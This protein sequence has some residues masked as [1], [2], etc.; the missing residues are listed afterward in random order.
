MIFGCSSNNKHEDKKVHI[1]SSDGVKNAFDVA[2]NTITTQSDYTKK[3]KLN[4]S[5]SIMFFSNG[6]D[7]LNILQMMTIDSDSNR[8]FGFMRSEKL[9][10]C[11]NSTNLY[12]S[13]FPTYSVLKKDGQ[14]PNDV[15][16]PIDMVY[17]RIRNRIY[18]ADLVAYAIYIYDTKFNEI[19][20]IKLQ[21]KPYRLSLGNDFLYVSP[22]NKSGNHC[23]IKINLK[24]KVVETDIKLSGLNDGL[25]KSMRNRLLITA[26]NDSSF[27]AVRQY[28]SFNIFKVTDNNIE[29]VFCDPVISKYK[30]PVP[31]EK[32]ID[33]DLRS[34][35]IKPYICISYEKNDKLLFTLTTLGWSELVQ[36]NNIKQTIVVYDDNGHSL[37]RYILSDQNADERSTIAYDSKLKLLY[38][39]CENY[40][41]K[42]KLK[43]N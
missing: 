15:V 13:S 19:D 14:G 35:A 40:V 38:Y 37:G 11:F 34:W 1:Y 36:Q 7:T 9:F 3:I 22:Y 32:M 42:F 29:G 31:Q 12:S 6:K 10:V 2:D 27:F 30:L 5:D 4:K 20:R 21:I 23:R 8:I 43:E 24:T 25:A 33:G 39:T 18:I 16:R 26:I 41:M 28:P 17:D